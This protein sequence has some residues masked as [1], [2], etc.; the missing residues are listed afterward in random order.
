MLASLTPDQLIPPDHPIRRV[1]PIVDAALA[2]L[3]PLFDAMYAEG[4]RPSIP[5]EHLLK[6]SLLMAFYS[7]RSE[8]QFCERLHY[9]LLFKWFLDMNLE[10]PAFDQSSFA[11]NRER[12]LDHEVSRAFFAAVLEQARERRLLS[13]EHFTVDGTLL[14][15]WASLKSL[16]RKPNLGGQR[17]PRKPRRGG[18]G[19]GSGSGRNPEVDFHGEPRSNQTHYSTTDPEA[20]LARKGTA[21]EAKLCLAGHVL[22]ENRNGLVVDV[23]VTQADGYA[24][25]SAGL[26]MLGR[27]QVRGRRT[28]GADKGY[29]TR[30]CVRGCRDLEVTPHV[31]QNQNQRRS[32]AIDGRVATQP[33]YQVSQRL[34]KRVE[35]IFGWWKTV[36]GGRKLRYLGVRRNRMWAEMTSAAFNLVRMSNLALEGA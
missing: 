30:D 19:R 21:R 32:S 20:L 17:K 36:A 4:G 1:K 22:M 3:S 35:E 26:V 23:E 13:R 33:G 11:K 18:G 24:E 2:D 10:D 27:T 7:I 16:E 6:A 12:L 28:V 29:D 9:D 14:E 8:R 34:R 5:P 31:A 25:R 15:S